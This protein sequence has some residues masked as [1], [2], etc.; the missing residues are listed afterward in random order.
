MFDKINHKSRDMTRAQVE[1][2][3]LESELKII[4]D[5]IRRVKRRINLQEGVYNAKEIGELKHRLVAVKSTM[6]KVCSY[7]TQDYN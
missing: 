6:T 1:L 4:Q 3:R 7:S 5:N 2:E